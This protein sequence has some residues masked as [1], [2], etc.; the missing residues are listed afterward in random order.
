MEREAI[1][2][3]LVRALIQSQFPAWSELPVEPVR[4]DGWDNRTF[5]LGDDMAV[6][7]PS[8]ERYAAAVE[9]EH[10]WLPVLAPNLPLP[11]PKPLAKGEPGLGYPWPWLVNRWLPGETLESSPVSDERQLA[12]DLAGFLTSLQRFDASNG[13]AFGRH[14]FFRGGPLRVYDDEIRSAIA[15]L[16]G[17][18]DATLALD[19]WEVALAATWDGRA[20]WIHGDVA[21]S[22]LLVTSGR[23]S[24]VIDFGSSAVGDAACD[25]TIAWTWF[26]GQGCETFAA[27]MPVDARTWQRA[28][29][30]SLWKALITMVGPSPHDPVHAE[31][32][33]NRVM[34]EHADG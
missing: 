2:A 7:L 20:V 29:G 28:R 18:I 31:R 26:S 1:D 19:T 3:A 8:A 24:G 13:P 15:R 33:A 30:W 34:A 16:A 27:A 6:R 9:K 17:R 12:V 14:N 5:R 22:N 32:I 21:A 10:R 23:L 11:I 4:P 25:L